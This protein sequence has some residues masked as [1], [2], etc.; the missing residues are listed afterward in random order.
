MK[1]TSVKITGV[2][3]I[4][5]ATQKTIG[6]INKDKALFNDLGETVVTQIVSSAKAGR[7]LNK[8]KFDN[9]SNSWRD[10][11]VKL[12]TV[13]NTDPLFQG[14]SKKS[15]LTFSGQLLNSFSFN[16]NLNQLSLGFFFKGSRKKYKG[17][18]KA[19]LDGPATNAEL[20]EE[21]EKTR[22]FV[23]ISQKLNQI[24]TLKVIK[25][26]RRNLQ[27]YKKLSRVLGSK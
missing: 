12:A 13:N 17:L 23:F 7:D 21:I 11:R 15:N 10:R 3:N 27:N 9:V 18:R 1:R 22:P 2:N 16:L 8:T 25:A 26:L 19:E 24:L 5:K 4:A 20:A 6:L 14:K